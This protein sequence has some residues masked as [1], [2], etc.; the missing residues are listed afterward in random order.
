MP[1]LL[2]RSEFAGD[3]SFLMAATYKQLR[4]PGRQ[5]RRVFLFLM[6]STAGVYSSCSSLVKSHSLQLS[7]SRSTA[8]SA[9]P[10]VVT[11]PRPWNSTNKPKAT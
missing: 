11:A 3:V 8:S 5:S 9:R 6:P 1:L 10:L 4:P 7:T 2:R